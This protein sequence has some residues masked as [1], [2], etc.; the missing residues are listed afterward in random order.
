MRNK[1]P[2]ILLAISSL[3]LFS[4]G[5]TNA[6]IEEDI[7]PNTPTAEEGNNIVFETTEAPQLV[8][9]DEQS[10]TNLPTDNPTEI[11]TESQ[12]DSESLCYHPYFP[13]LDG[14]YWTFDALDDEDYTL[15]IEE[16]GENS[17]T[18][19]QEMAQD[20][21]IY[22]VD[23]FCSEQGILRGSFGQLDLLNQAAPD[24]EGAEFEF[25]AL[26]WEG[27]TLPAPELMVVGH[28]WTS[29]YKLA[30]NLDIEGISQTSEIQVSIDHEVAAIESVSVPAGTFSEAIRVDSL[31]QIDM[32]LI[33]GESTM[34][35]TGYDFS[36]STW[37]VEG[38]GM[39][40]SSNQVSGYSSSVELID[41][42]F[43]N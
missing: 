21:L 17:F 35:L 14:A 6:S 20:D 34:P 9:T 4:C 10:P 26:V 27:E 43:L 23:W 11:P 7:Q 15:R 29:N 16:T 36:Y 12:A 40:K 3:F 2:F 31:G 13:I 32:V 30:A 37:Y 19:S 41:T 28:T 22:T 1:I 25:E 38:I 5:S 24:E 18:M 42:S 33:M 39:V 8:I